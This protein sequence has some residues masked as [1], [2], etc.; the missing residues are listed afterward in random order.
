M[1][2]QRPGAVL[3]FYRA[4]ILLVSVLSALVLAIPFAVLVASSV[5][6]E[7]FAEFPPHGFTLKWYASVLTD[8]T[9]LTPFWLSIV[10]S[11]VATAVAVLF[12]TAGALAVARLGR[13]PARLVRTLF[14]IPMALPPVAYAVGLYGLQLQM[15]FLRSSLLLL[16]LGEALLAVPYVFIVVSAGVGR[17]DPALRSAAATMGAG[18]PLIVRRVELPLLVPGIVAGA[19]FGFNL[20]FDEVTLAVF[21]MPPGQSTLPLKMLNSTA[22]S[23]TPQLTAASTMVSLLALVVLAGFSRFSGQGRARRARKGSI[24]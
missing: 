20:V 9:W 18:W 21:L 22:D 23:F 24:A 4:P 13:N 1:T 2:V 7:V 19:L 15:M 11:C 3:G 14:I 12:G 10:V 16:V 8:P 6:T 5:T 17:I